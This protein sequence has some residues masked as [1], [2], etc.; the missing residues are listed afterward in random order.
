MIC[1]KP[2]GLGLADCAAPV[3]LNQVT[4]LSYDFS[5]PKIEHLT[6]LKNQRASCERLRSC[7]EYPPIIDPFKFTC[8]YVQT[9]AYNDPK[10]ALL[11]RHAPG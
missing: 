9:F 3:M 11:S 2:K 8:S 4:G 7:A 1:S 10:P 5:A 6:K